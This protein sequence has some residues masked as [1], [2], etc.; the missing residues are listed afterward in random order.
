MQ[1]LVLVTLFSCASLD[2]GGLTTLPT[3]Y[4]M[5]A[6]VVPIAFMRT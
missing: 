4:F 5:M 6:I 2:L 1:L 3:L